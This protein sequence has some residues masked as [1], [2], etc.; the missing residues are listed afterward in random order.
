LTMEYEPVPRGFA[1]SLLVFALGLI[2]QEHPLAAGVAASVA[3]LYHPPTTLPFWGLAILL[4]FARRLRWTILI[5][6]AAA[7]AVLALLARIQHPGIEAQSL[8]RRLEPFQQS[9]QRMRAAYS[10]VS[11][12][13]LNTRISLAVQASI[14]ALA[15]WRVRKVM[16]GPLRDFLFGMPVLGL[17]SIPLSWLLLERGHW[18]LIPAWQPARAMLF[19]SLI[20]ALLAAIA[21]MKATNFSERLV[22]LIAAFLIPMQHVV[23]GAVIHLRPVQLAAALGIVAA[24]LMFFNQ[25]SRGASLVLAGLI[26][27][28]VI[29]Q[30]KLVENYPHLE[31]TELRA[32][33]E[34]ARTSTPQPALFLFPDSGTSLDPGI[35]RARALRGLYVDWNSGGQVNYCPEF[36]SEW[37]AHWVETG[38][39]RWTVTAQDFPKLA[40]MGVDYVVLKKPM[41][42]T[43]AQFAGARYFAYATSSRDSR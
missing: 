33:A 32:L 31:T 13:N 4:V 5:P 35:F 30:S 11:S 40:S 28:F 29:P 25:K 27:F 8:M 2:A 9:L 16:S 34:W 18:A 23:S 7:G 15:F 21:A 37:W 17:L 19:V 14:V 39:G 20:A 42:G 41:P 10:F 1:I 3:I 12:W 38:S 24:A 43:T 22:W 26:P 6:L 36:S